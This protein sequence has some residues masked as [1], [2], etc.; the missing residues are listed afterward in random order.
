MIKNEI[1]GKKLDKIYS[2]RR[3]RF[4]RKRKIRRFG[5][6]R[7]IVLGTFLTLVI[8]VIS[9]VLSAYPIFV[10]SCKNAAAS[11]AVHIVNDEIQ[12]I[13]KDYAYNDLMEIEKDGD[14]NVV[15]AKFNTVLINEITTKIATNIQE[16]IDHTPTIMVC[17]NLGSVSGVSIL[18]K[19]GPHF[20]IEL[21]AAGRTN[22]EIKSEFES[23]NVNQ[24]AHKIYLELATNVNILTPIGVYDKNLT[25]KVLLTEAV[26]VGKV[27]ETYYNLEG[28]N[29]ENTLDVID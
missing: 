23:I 3:I 18:K 28:L 11:K 25:S 16:K 2:R 7:A 10:A 22:T 5:K 17:L 21:E 12:N 15:F 26:I 20:N 1:G 14:G 29:S 24:T 4:S 13:M 8:A 27:P 9:F 19:L 6:V